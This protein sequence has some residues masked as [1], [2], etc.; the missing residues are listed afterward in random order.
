MNDQP[1]VAYYRVSTRMQKKSGLGL[2]AQRISVRNYIKSHPG[3]LI[4][5]L[6]EVESGLKCDRPVIQE[7]L[8]YCRVYGAMLVVAKLDRLARSTA[9]IAALM[10]SGVD[11]VT[12]D[13]PMANRFTL[14]ILAA[15]A[16]Y[17]ARL[18]SE[19]T[20]AA[21]AAAKARGT[22]L[23]SYPRG[24]PPVPEA[25]LKAATRARHERS[26]ARAR[27]YAPL[28]CALRDRGETLAGIAAHLAL[29]G[30]EPINH[31]R[32]WYP[33][34]IKKI[35][36]IVGEPP[37]KPRRGYRPDQRGMQSPPLLP[38]LTGSF[39]EL[40]TE[41]QFQVPPIRSTEGMIATSR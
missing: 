10:E 28:F 19:R 24:G 21:F 34:V 1:L 20:K 32:T 3:K 29:M 18:I 11:F 37:P 2:D 6:T 31:G 40:R 38:H 30:I 5:E 35:F 36:Q 26:I 23:R 22:P 12:A 7:A 41:R 8:W 16:E 14:H 25:T 17:E 4:A 13:V 33:S 9:L 39:D 15:V 27:Q